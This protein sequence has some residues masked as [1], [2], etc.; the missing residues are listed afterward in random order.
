MYE[1][2]TYD[3]LLA[4]GKAQIS[5][6]ILK[7]EGSLVHNALSVIAYQLEQFYIQAGYLMEQIDP[8]T[9]DYDNLVMLCKQRGIYPS[10]ATQ[11]V[12]KI[13]ANVE[14]PIGA[15][16][17]LN[18]FSYT[19][20]EAI[21][22]EEY[23]YRATCGTAGSE[24]NTIKGTLTPITYVKGLTS[25]E[26]TEVLVE[27]EDATTQAELLEEYINSFTN[28]SFGGNVTQYKEEVS[29]IT[30]I[31]GCKVFPVWNGGGTVK[32]VVISSSHNTVSDELVQTV[33]NTICPA[34]GKGYGI[35]PIGHD[36][37]VVSVTGKAINITTSITYASG[38]SWD[39]IGDEITAAIEAY[40]LDLRAA[41]DEG[42]ET[43][44]VTAYVSRTEA[45]IL[46]VTGVLDV[47]GTMLNGESVK[48]E[49]AWD[50]VPILGEIAHD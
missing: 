42:S 22:G 44:F 36:V 27:G 33:Q 23:A 40:F 24:P 41:W 43:D 17:S 8:S 21:E 12:V 39:T 15:R 49:L 16:F 50:E 9:A 28:D 2:K 38:E 20:T 7:N 3:N 47:S 4:E 34:S 14:L 6:S 37:T 32:I 30:G 25:A 35:A 29:E 46:E 18:I 26:I 11:A 19:V 13:V 10:D 5:D 45:K 48:L 31:G 1:D